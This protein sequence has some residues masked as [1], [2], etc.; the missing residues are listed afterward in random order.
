M[1]F[2]VNTTTVGNTLI[3]NIDQSSRSTD[4]DLIIGKNFNLSIKLLSLFSP[5]YEHVNMYD[6]NMAVVK[7]SIKGGLKV[8]LIILQ[9]SWS[10][11]WRHSGI[12]FVGLIKCL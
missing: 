10:S 3:W 11:S 5:T 2:K 1:I 9:I 4:T 6:S 12:L 8:S 7:K